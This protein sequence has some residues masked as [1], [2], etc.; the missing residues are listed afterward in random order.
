MQVEVCLLLGLAATVEDLWRR[1]ISNRTVLAG[2]AA[3]LAV[4]V[5]LR[6][7]WRGPGM[8]LAGATAGFLVFLVFYFAGGMGGGDIKLMTAFGGCLGYGQIL[9]AALLTAIVGAVLACALLAWRGIR[10]S[11]VQAPGEG[12]NNLAEETIPYA[13][14]ICLGALLSFFRQ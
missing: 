11:H 13:P 7:W 12:A 3:G 9:W 4:Q 10:W 5:S 8:W 14:A 1:R 6:G 2:L